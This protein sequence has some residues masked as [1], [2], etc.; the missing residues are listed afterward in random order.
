MWTQPA[1]AGTSALEGAGRCR[2][3]CRPSSHPGDRDRPAGC[4]RH[5]LRTEETTA[6]EPDVVDDT[7]Y[8]RGIG[9]VFEARSRARRK[10][11]G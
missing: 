1:Q 7:V 8:D 2:S 4:F 6:L 5:A 3:P 10:H 9:E 11:C